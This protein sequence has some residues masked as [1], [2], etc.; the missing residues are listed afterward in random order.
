VE[1]I[2]V[3]NLARIVRPAILLITAMAKAV[4]VALAVLSPTNW[5]VR[6]VS[7]SQHLMT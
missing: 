5:M 2:S 4:V 1:T 7:V 3:L 6:M